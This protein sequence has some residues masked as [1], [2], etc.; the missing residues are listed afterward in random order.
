[1][2]LIFDTETT[3]L[4]S[5]KLRVIELAWIICDENQNILK[6]ESHLIYPKGFFVPAAATKVNQITNEMLHKDGKQIENVL[7][8]FADDVRNV[9]YIIAHNISFDINALDKEFRL[10]GIESPLHSVRQICTMMASVNFC[11][12]SK[13][14]GR[15]GY[16][17]PKLQE[18]YLRLFS[19]YFDGSHRALSDA[20]ACKECFFKLVDLGEV[21]LKQRLYKLPIATQKKNASYSNQISRA[22][23]HIGIKSNV[24]SSKP[25]FQ[26]TTTN[27]AVQSNDQKN[28]LVSSK[29]VSASFSD[30]KNIQAKKSEGFVNYRWIDFLIGCVII[31]LIASSIQTFKTQPSKQPIIEQKEAQSKRQE[32]LKSTTPQPSLS[33]VPKKKELRYLY[34][35]KGSMWGFFDDD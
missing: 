7:T 14:N 21:Q 28:I 26:T 31:M 8:K 33:A 16:K 24:V 5:S 13:L 2:F 11:R 19:N 20:I 27:S 15:Q 23:S 4:I 30:P 3:G 10:A 32:I 17:R 22:D 35:S 34:Y 12:L 1:M 29:H 6:Q 18:L 9:E 25:T